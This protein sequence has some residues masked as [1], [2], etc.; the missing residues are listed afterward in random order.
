M[1]NVLCV[2]PSRLNSSRLPKKALLPIQGKPMVQW[3]YENAAR[4]PFFSEVIVATDSEEIAETIQK[5]G[6]KVAMT[7]SELQN[8]TERVAVVAERYPEMD[9]VINVQGDGPF[10]KPSMLERLLVPYFNGEMPDMAT[11]AFPLQKDKHQDPAAV[12]VVLD[13]HGNAIYFSRLPIP[14]C[15]TDQANHVY[16]H[17]GVYAF[18][19]DFLL[20]YAS[21][22][23][24]PLEKAES[25]EQLRVLEHGHKVRV[26]LT[27]E[28]ALDINTPQEYHQAQQLVYVDN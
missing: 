7:S 21:L 27:T 8:G 25:L 2:V 14:Y 11:L 13:V 3:A 24:T 19:R 22:P 1:V 23:P 18:R 12:K 20:K 5:I 26:C 6:G 15:K 9:V 28:G 10:I 16:H 17:M 4:C